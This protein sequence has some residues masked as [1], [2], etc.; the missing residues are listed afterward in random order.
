M[1][2]LIITTLLSI[3]T[4]FSCNQ[5]T[6]IPTLPPE[7]TLQ[8]R[9]NNDPEV[10]YTRKLQ[11]EYSRALV[12]LQPD[13]LLGALS[14]IELCGLNPASADIQDLDKCLKDAPA[15]KRYI[16]CAQLLRLYETA[17][18]SVESRYPELAT[19]HT[20]EKNRMVLLLEEGPALPV[21]RF[22]P[23]TL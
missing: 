21:D 19:L 18:R 22:T 8:N 16:R 5:S 15:R 7:T 14:K 17:L 13:E 2:I 12:A 3:T 4:F 1:K 9:L 20:D 23:P 10:L 11:A 6:G